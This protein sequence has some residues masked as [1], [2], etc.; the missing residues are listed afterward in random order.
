MEISV[1]IFI[2]I[3]TYKQRFQNKFDIWPKAGSS[4][5]TLGHKFGSSKRLNKR[6][7]PF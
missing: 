6:F 3:V 2:N 1:S 4:T 5:C 7:F